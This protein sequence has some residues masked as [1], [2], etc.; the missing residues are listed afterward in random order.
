MSHFR[1][2]HCIAGLEAEAEW[3]LGPVFAA[4]PAAF[5]KTGLSAVRYHTSGQFIYETD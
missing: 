2:D 3:E 1:V 5:L 4:L